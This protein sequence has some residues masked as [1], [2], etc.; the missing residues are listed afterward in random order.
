MTRDEALTIL[1]RE[2]PRL[3]ERYGIKQIGLF[4]SVARDEASTESDVDVIVDVAIESVWEYLRLIEEVQGAF[5]AKVD[6][7]RLQ[8]GL[9]PRFRD[10]IE[11]DA[12][13]A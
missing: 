2:K 13:Y 6:V 5:P 10:S 9:R 11:R 3:T 8:A 4:G 12:I 7:V 1:R